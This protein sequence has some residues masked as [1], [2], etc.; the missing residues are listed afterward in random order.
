MEE[1]KSGKIENSCGENSCKKNIYDCAVPL[2]LA[3][4]FNMDYKKLEKEIQESI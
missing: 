3:H 4:K 2:F 1:E